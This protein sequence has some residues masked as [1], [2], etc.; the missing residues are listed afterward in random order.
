MFSLDDCD[1]Y[2]TDFVLATLLESSP[3]SLP[4][5]AT[6]D[7]KITSPDQRRDLSP[8]RAQNV[9]QHISFDSTD[10]DRESLETSVSI[11]HSHCI[12]KLPQEFSQFDSAKV[13]GSIKSLAYISPTLAPHPMD[14]DYIVHMD[15]SSPRPLGVMNLAGGVGRKDRSPRITASTTTEELMDAL[16]SVEKNTRDQRVI[17]NNQD[18][19]DCSEAL[20]K[21]HTTDGDDTQEAVSVLP[22]REHSV[23]ALFYIWRYPNDS[24]TNIEIPWFPGKVTNDVQP[25][26]TCTSAKVSLSCDPDLHSTQG[27][28][29]NDSEF[30]PSTPPSKKVGQRRL[31]L[32]L[33]ICVWFTVQERFCVLGSWSVWKW[34]EQNA[35]SCSRLRGR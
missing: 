17:S 34:T 30:L 6:I 19:P 33:V 13:Q 28:I 24:C 35:S 15:P 14:T 1:D 7:L 4:T 3:S 18:Q 26:S 21:Y 22:G 11:E 23:H 12:R 25:L 29:I 5:T 9:H 27:S 32:S 8:K 31:N 20:T 16:F 10:I 2:Q